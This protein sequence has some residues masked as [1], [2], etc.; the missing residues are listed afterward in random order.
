M[1]P[2]IKFWL[3]HVAWFIKWIE[4]GPQPVLLSSAAPQIFISPHVALLAKTLNTTGL[5]QRG[6]C[7]LSFGLNGPRF[8]L[9]RFSHHF[10]RA[11]WGRAETKFY[12]VPSCSFS[13]QR[14]KIVQKI[15]EEEETFLEFTF[16]S[17]KVCHS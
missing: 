11:W 6:C 8:Q 12:D 17:P 2:L 9:N 16:L 5:R 3:A 1:R 15:R 10:G 7:H 4:Y 14:R 13:N